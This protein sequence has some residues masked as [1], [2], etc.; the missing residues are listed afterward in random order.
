MSERKPMSDEE[1][2]NWFAQDRSISD[3][4]E[5]TKRAR[6]EAAHLREVNEALVKALKLSDAA[7]R[8]AHLFM[9]HRSKHENIIAGVLD[10]ASTEI[11][12]ALALALAKKEG[13]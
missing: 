7:M 6:A 12:A 10:E 1:F 11:R 13:S 3:L 9:V 2:E 8:R 5:E 4:W